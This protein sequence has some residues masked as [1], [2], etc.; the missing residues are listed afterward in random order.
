MSLFRLIASLGQSILA[1]SAMRIVLLLL[2]V[3]SAGQA[4]SVFEGTAEYGARMA[5]N[6]TKG[7]IFV[8]ELKSAT[9]T[10]QWLL[11]L[12]DSPRPLE[13]GESSRSWMTEQFQHTL[14][15]STGH[16][17]SFPD[18][19]FAMDVEMVGP[20]TS[21]SSTPDV[22]RD[23][24]IGNRLYFEH[25]LFSTAVIDDRVLRAGH[26]IPE[27]ALLFRANYPKERMARDQ[28]AMAAVGLTAEDEKEIAR[29]AFALN[30]FGLI[31]SK[32][33]AFREILGALIDVPTLFHGMYINVDWRKL[34]RSPPDTNARRVR[35]T[36]P[37]ELVTTTRLSG[38]VSFVNPQSI[39]LF[40]AGIQEV[41]FDHSEKSPTI[42]LHIWLFDPAKA[43]DRRG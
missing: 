23:R 27:L 11:C 19:P 24:A 22:H 38:R 17:F 3:A 4:Q 6:A 39:F 9:E 2:I 8:C 13:D 37:L 31:A 14:H 30:Q 43:S 1:D 28:A 29:A 40:S 36:A 35:F 41:W 12:R 42:S 25:G 33:P 5:K 15:S 20:F 26:I 16:D 34:E 7:V 21:T 10:K 32:M 18:E